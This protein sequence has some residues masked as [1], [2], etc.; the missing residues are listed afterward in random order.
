MKKNFWLDVLLFVSGL[1]CI[2][3]G[4]CLDFHL[5]GRED[6]SARRLIRNI[7]IY[8]GYIMAIGLILHIAWHGGWL[9]AAA[10]QLFGK[11]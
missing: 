7:H 9:K 2:V 6:F 3:T 8:T 1:A 11:D 5:V 10:K 4:I